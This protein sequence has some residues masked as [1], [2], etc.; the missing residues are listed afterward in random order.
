MA[1]P[2]FIEYLLTLQAPGGGRLT[3]YNVSQWMGTAF[4]PN[5]TLSYEGYPDPCYALI[6]FNV[7]F[8]PIM[9]PN[10]FDIFGEQYG[11]RMIG[12]TVTALV[13]DH[14]FD[15]Y[16]VITA[17][18]PYRGRIINNTP[19]LQWFE[20]LNSFLIITSEENLK[21]LIEH[22]H[23]L[24]TG[25]MEGLAAQANGL[26]TAIAKAYQPRRL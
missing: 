19:L 14:Q 6:W 17:A 10:A 4:P 23:K 16:I 25:K 8:S 2:Y 1:L 13:L 7:D 12:G 11:A 18:S 24:T 20:T 15:W 21:L 26:L 5:T 3:E 9:V 22:L